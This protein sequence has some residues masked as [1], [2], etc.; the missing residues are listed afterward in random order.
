MAGEHRLGSIDQIPPGEGRNF[1]VAGRPVAVFRT[2][3]DNVFATQAYCPHKAGPLADG[4]V[5]S[6]VVVC[7]LHDWRFDLATGQPTSGQC[8]IEVYPVRTTEDRE[9]VLTLDGG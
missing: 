8:G 9:I 1:E 2:R 5:G 4:M 3:D 7:P 6:R